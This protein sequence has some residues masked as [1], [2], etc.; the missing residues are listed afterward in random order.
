MTGIS[1][2]YS[3]GTVVT[4]A[5]W[6]TLFA[7]CFPTTNVSSYSA[8]LVAGSTQAAWFTALGLPAAAPG[9]ANGLATLNGSGVVPN[10]QIPST[11]L[12]AMYPQGAWNATT[13]NPALASGTGTKGFFYVVTTGGTT[14][15]DGISVWN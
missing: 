9:D 13:N 7:Q 10:G 15:L 1:F 5:Q 4:A 2:P 11:L 3:T 14:A 8:G 6:T 12:G